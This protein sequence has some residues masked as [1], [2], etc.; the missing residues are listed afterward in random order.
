MSRLRVTCL[1]PKGL[2]V[3][4]EQ[5][6]IR[7]YLFVAKR[8][9]WQAGYPERLYGQHKVTKAARRNQKRLVTKRVNIGGWA[10][11]H[12]VL[13]SHVRMKTCTQART[14]MR[15]KGNACAY[16]CMGTHAAHLLLPRCALWH[17]AASCWWLWLLLPFHCAPA[18]CDPRASLEALVHTWR[19][20]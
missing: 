4:Y 5:R 10:H 14:G 2:S 11:A 6:M 8:A 19:R 16:T 13:F 17:S 3:L 18:Q 7:R 20:L 12:S 1:S 9:F 15:T